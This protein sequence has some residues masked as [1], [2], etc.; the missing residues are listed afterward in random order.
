MAAAWALGVVLVVQVL[1]LYT[2]G[3]PEPG[4]FPWPVGTDK[5]VHLFLFGVPAFLIRLVTQRWWPIWLLVVHVPI[6]EFI[7][8]TFIPHRY[9][10]PTDM[11]A[12]LIGIALGVL[13]ARSV[14]RRRSPV[15][16]D[17]RP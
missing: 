11:V 1:M 13:A 4:G 5:V 10:D 6:S 3:S 16:P 7:Q 17:P 12:D 9:G 15:R 14:G 2:P 8:L